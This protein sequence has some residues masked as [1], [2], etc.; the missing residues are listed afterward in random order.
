[1]MAAPSADDRPVPPAV[2]PRRTVSTSTVEAYLGELAASLAGQIDPALEADGI[3]TPLGC[4]A[5]AALLEA[6]GAD[7]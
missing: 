2:P 5:R 6:I 4:V 7:L 3:I 1:M